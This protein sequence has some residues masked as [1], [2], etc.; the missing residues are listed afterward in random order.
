MQKIACLFYT[1]AQN[2]QIP[3]AADFSVASNGIETGVS[4]LWLAVTGQVPVECPTVLFI[5]VVDCNPEIEG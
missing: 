4:C 3:M 1:R 2:P 5:S